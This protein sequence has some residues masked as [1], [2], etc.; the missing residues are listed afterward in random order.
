MLDDDF[1]PKTITSESIKIPS[2]QLD[3]S[4]EIIAGIKTSPDENTL[5]LKKIPMHTNPIKKLIPEETAATIIWEKIHS[6]V[7]MGVAISPTKLKS[8]RSFKRV[9][10]RLTAPRAKT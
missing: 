4:K 3:I 5:N 10:A 2:V 9:D 1:F 6:A 8:D 7:V